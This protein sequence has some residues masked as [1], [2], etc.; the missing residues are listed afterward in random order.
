MRVRAT[1]LQPCR[2][3]GKKRN[4]K[5]VVEEPPPP[6]VPA[7]IQPVKKEN[8][9]KSS[10]SKSKQPPAS[11]PSPR[12]QTP[13]AN[14]SSPSTNSAFSA[15]INQ[16]L[17][18][19]NASL[20][21]MATMIDNFTD[22]QL[23]SNHISSTVLDSP[24]SYDYTTGSYIDNRNFYNQ[25]PPGSEPYGYPD[26]CE[27]VKSRGSEENPDSTTLSTANSA[28]SPKITD[29]N[30]FSMLDDTTKDHG[31]AKP[32]PKPPEY[33]PN[34]G[35][36]SNKPAYSPMYPPYTPYE[37]Y[38]N[39][40]YYSNDKLR[41][42]FYNPHHHQPYPQY[43]M[44][45]S[46]PAMSAPSP[47]PQP[48]WNM[49][50][51]SPSP[52]PIHPMQPQMQQQP[53]PKMPELATPTSEP[54]GEITEINDNLECFQDSQM[55]GVGIALGHGSVLIEC[56]KHEMHAT[57]AL[58]KPNRLN[59]TRITL[60][61]YQHRNLNRHKHG[62]EE[63]EEKMRL[64]KLGITAQDVEDAKEKAIKVEEEIKEEAKDEP[65]A[66]EKFELDYEKLNRDKE[67]VSLRAPTLTTTSW[68]TLFPMHPCV[69]TGPYQEGNNPTAGPNATDG[70]TQPSQPQLQQ[71]Q[72]HLQPQDTFI[73][74]KLN[75][76]YM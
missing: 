70:S 9:K 75:E 51:P 76:A 20:I 10:K 16:N 36:H 29:P 71:Q 57:T 13:Q 47:T 58:R 63:W 26:R 66:S 14:N 17:M 27:Q 24:Y 72:Q 62:I 33:P 42:N 43:N 37:H 41:Y 39:M 59:P 34:Y 52:M 61:F 8:S 44:Y 64:K 45:H 73:P 38:N 53:P 56:A 60:I 50:P 2:R 15:P 68:T 54:I 28:F 74:P 6:S 67:E 30:K 48:N 49:Y 12:A 25:W 5:E 11:S 55:G 40:D 4:G 31:F 23:Q 46:N 35:Y 65:M 3:H 18:N 22:A 21:N 1:P 19:T 32:H 69:V 7:E